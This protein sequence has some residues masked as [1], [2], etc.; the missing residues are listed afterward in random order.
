MKLTIL[1]I[2]PNLGQGGAQ[3]VFRDQ[4]DYYSKHH[5]VIGCVFNWDHS[6]QE[7]RKLS[8]ISLD[9]PAGRNVLTK[10]YFF[11]KRISRLKKI[12]E[13]FHVDIA[14]SHLEGADYIN[15]LSRKRE[16]VITWIH[17]T[18]QFDKNISGILGTLR[19]KIFIPLL[20]RHS[21]RVI[22]VSYGIKEEL[23]HYFSLLKRNIITV[24]NGIST[25]DILFYSEKEISKD[26]LKLSNN[27]S[28]LI[29]HCR[30]A[31]QKN[32]TALLQIM[33][34]LPKDSN[35]KLVILGDGELRGTLLTQCSLLNLR[36]FSTWNNDQWTENFD[37]YFLGYQSNPYPYLKHAA[38]YLMTSL[39]EGFPLSLCEALACGLPIL[40]ADCY[41]GPREIL[42]PELPLGEPLLAPYISP[43]GVLMPIPNSNSQIDIWAETIIT[44]I[45]DGELRSV[46]ST[47]AVKRVIDF[48]KSNVED[49]WLKILSI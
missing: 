44:I 2:I 1:L 49:K 9:V 34:S 41:T 4:F 46:L 43:Y 24:N 32:L 13:Q 38:L 36:S 25:A 26:F 8:I 11:W 40:A 45:G 12:K 35:L 17:G 19:K 31:Q 23:I 16:K 42:C 33:A 20:Y 10:V 5:N 15:I 27:Y 14:I 22:T 18:K 39:W 6:F 28:I 37:V 7:D 3:T 47:S 29:T 21:D 30:L 48:D